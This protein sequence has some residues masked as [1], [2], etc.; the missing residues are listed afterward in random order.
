M[1]ISDAYGCTAQSDPFY[2]DYSGIGQ[3]ASG[4]VT[5]M[6]NPTTGVV[7]IAG[8]F[9]YMCEYSV[10]VFNS[11]GKEISSSFNAASI[12]LSPFHN[13]LYIVVIKTD[14][15]VVI[16]NKVILNK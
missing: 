4:D 5:L 15:G 11:L 6:P 16:T 1:V 9:L 10:H 3:Y 14:A 7:N 12:D 13:G 2:F 8:D